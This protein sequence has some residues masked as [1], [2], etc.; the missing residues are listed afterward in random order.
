MYTSE[1]SNRLIRTQNAHFRVLGRFWPPLDPPP[2]P[3]PGGVKMAQIG[4][5]GGV[6][7]TPLGGLDPPRGA[8]DP[9]PG[10]GLEG[11]QKDPFKHLETGGPILGPENREN[12]PFSAILA[13]FGPFLA[14]F[15]P[16]GHFWAPG[17]EIGIL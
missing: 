6:P 8:G 9:P 7:Q 16:R 1:V 11:V 3:P 10:G 13:I 5:W 17:G 4:P 15:W 14:H 12:T 2:G